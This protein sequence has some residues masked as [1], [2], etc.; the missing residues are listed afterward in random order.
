VS[1]K[2]LYVA[3]TL[4]YPLSHT[5]LRDLVARVCAAC[6]IEERSAELTRQLEDAVEQAQPRS[7]GG[8]YQVRFQ[9]QDG[10]LDVAVSDGTQ[11]LWHIT[12][13]ID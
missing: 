2:A 10:S 13:P 7:R 1:S 6:G 4:A 11:Q 12:R 3:V 5:L 9:A 8:D